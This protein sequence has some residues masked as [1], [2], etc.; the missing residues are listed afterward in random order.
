MSFFTNLFSN[1]MPQSA[2]NTVLISDIAS[3][4]GYDVEEIIAKALELGMD[5]KNAASRVSPEYA[6]AIFEYTT[7]GVIPALIEKHQR[8]NGFSKKKSR[9]KTNSI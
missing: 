9:I 2:E 8:N 3:D 6:E 5:V 1:M 4:L 7:S